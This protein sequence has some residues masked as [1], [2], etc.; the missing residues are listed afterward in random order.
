MSHWTAQS[1]SEALRT[2]TKVVRVDATEGKA[3][4]EGVPLCKASPEAAPAECS[5]PDA[6]AAAPVAQ[7]KPRKRGAK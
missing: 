1:L 6:G 4:T 7:P 3:L 2:L 5:T